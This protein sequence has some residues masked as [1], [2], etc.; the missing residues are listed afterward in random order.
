MRKIIEFSTSDTAFQLAFLHLGLEHWIHL[1]YE[2]LR[3]LPI[4]PVFAKTET[5]F[6]FICKY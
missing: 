4:T 5:E 1:A 6:G 2:L 3:K